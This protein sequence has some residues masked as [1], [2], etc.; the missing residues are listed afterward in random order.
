MSQNAHNNGKHKPCRSTILTVDASFPSYLAVLDLLTVATQFTNLILV[1][2]TLIT[3]TADAAVLTCMI[4]VKFH[5]DCLVWAS[6]L[7]T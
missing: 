5:P 4:Q 3:S 2:T 7:Y 6:G 1:S